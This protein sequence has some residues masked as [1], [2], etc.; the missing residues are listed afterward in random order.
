MCMLR[1]YCV[2]TRDSQFVAVCNWLIQ[3]DIARELHL[4]RTRFWIDDS[5]VL[6]SELVL[7]FASSVFTVEHETN[8][9]LG[10]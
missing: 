4:N 10:I 7:R 2:Y 6:H 8:H 5:S 1:H 9:T 3:H